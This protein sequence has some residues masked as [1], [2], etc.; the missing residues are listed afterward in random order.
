MK[1]PV[2]DLHCDTASGL[3]RRRT[4][5]ADD[6]LK[7]NTLH[8]DLERAAALP[9]Y[10][11]CF[12]CFTTDRKD[13]GIDRGPSPLVFFERQM[14]VIY[15]Q[16]EANS[17][18]IRLAFSGED[19]QSNYEKGLMST[20]MTIEG[21]AGFGFDPALLEDMYKVPLPVLILRAAALRTWAR[22]ML[23]KRRDW[24]CGSM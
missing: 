14:D 3:V 21:P 24:E 13:P 12:A 22:S 5:G 16:V 11:Q 18:R 17:D 9:G 19:V 7:K 8:I 15:S 4:A 10:S 20:I 23:R 6:T 2:F 1:F